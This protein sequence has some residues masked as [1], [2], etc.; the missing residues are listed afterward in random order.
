MRK[1]QKKDRI[2]LPT[3]ENMEGLVSIPKIPFKK[4]LKPGEDLSE[5]RLCQKKIIL[6]KRGRQVKTLHNRNSLAV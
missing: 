4:C 6:V 3:L 5:A 1:I 2:T